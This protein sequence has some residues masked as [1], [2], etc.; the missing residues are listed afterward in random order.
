MARKI[1]QLAAAII[2]IL[3]VTSIM[4]GGALSTS[5]PSPE[6]YAFLGVITGA[7]SLFLFTANTKKNG[8]VITSNDE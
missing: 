4:F 7:A 3:A 6:G 1:A 5:E 2:L 8:T